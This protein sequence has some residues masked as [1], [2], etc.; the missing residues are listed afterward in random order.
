MGVIGLVFLPYF[1]VDLQIDV[2]NDII[3]SKK[4][5]EEYGCELYGYDEDGEPCD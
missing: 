4:D 5:E 1:S 3:Q 2:M